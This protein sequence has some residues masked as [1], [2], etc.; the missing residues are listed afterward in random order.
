MKDDW[1]PIR[2]NLHED[3]HVIRM[4]AALDTSTFEVVGLLVQF[5][6]WSSTNSDDGI[7]SRLDRDTLRTCLPVPA[8]VDALFDVGWLD[9]TEDGLAIPHFDLWMSRSANRRLKER[10]RKRKAR[11]SH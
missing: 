9:E 3:I 11:E 7:L 1:L 4:A 8:L 10:E 5:W 6:G 2:H